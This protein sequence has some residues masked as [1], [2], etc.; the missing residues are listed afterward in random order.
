M[1]AC[2]L[3]FVVFLTKAADERIKQLEA[4]LVAG[5]QTEIF[6]KQE[7]E[8]LATLGGAANV[9]CSKYNIFQCLWRVKVSQK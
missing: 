9:S 1:Y 2:C 7:V 3:M 5:K 6:L 8:R 4:E